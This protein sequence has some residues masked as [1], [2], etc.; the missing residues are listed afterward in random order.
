MRRPIVCLVIL[1]GIIYTF[2]A[3]CNVQYYGDLFAM[4]LCNCFLA[5]C[6]NSDHLVVIDGTSIPA[7]P[8]Q[9]TAGCVEVAIY[10]SFDNDAGREL[11]LTAESLASTAGPTWVS[12]TRSTKLRDA[13]GAPLFPVAGAVN[14]EA[15]AFYA[16]RARAFQVSTSPDDPRVIL[17]Y[18]AQLYRPGE[19]YGEILQGPLVVLSLEY[20]EAYKPYTVAGFSL[21]R[22]VAFDES[23]H[24]VDIRRDDVEDEPIAN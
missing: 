22:E 20:S 9:E 6:E 21:A 23:G 1:L 4:Q 7:V 11:I 18:K 13:N 14:S 19:L 3:G 16:E 8:D 10:R 5:P 24:V 12:Q 15:L 17:R 2:S